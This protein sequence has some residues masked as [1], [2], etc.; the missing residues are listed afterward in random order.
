MAIEARELEAELRNLGGDEVMDRNDVWGSEGPDMRSQ[1][2]V[3]G[4]AG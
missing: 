3:V 2:G 1:P 4:R